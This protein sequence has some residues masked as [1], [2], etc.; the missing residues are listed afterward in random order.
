MTKLEEMITYLSDEQNKGKNELF[1]ITVN[2]NNTENDEMLINHV[3]QLESK[4]KYYK[5][6]YDN[7]LKHNHANVIVTDY[8]FIPGGTRLSDELE[9]LI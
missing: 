9:D 6:T 5:T 1:Y 8:G 2:I 7:N 4:V 3:N